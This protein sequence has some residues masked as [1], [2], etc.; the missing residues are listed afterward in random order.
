MRG[1]P[2]VLKFKD[3]QSDQPSEE[4]KAARLEYWNNL[5]VDDAGELLNFAL[6]LDHFNEYDRDAPEYV[7]FYEWLDAKPNI[8]TNSDGRHDYQDPPFPDFMQDAVGL[9]RMMPGAVERF[10]QANHAAQ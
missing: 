6:H 2:V 4:E 10:I 8:G 9:H 1:M 7:E 3:I 5:S